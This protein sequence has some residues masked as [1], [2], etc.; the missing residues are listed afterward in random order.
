MH[1][2][3]FA[4]TLPVLAAMATAPAAA[5]AEPL[6]ATPGLWEMTS[7]VQMHGPVLSP[8]MMA[9][10]PPSAR[11]QVEA[12]MKTMQQPHTSR[13]CITEQKLR[14]GF[15]FDQSR[16]GSCQKL[17][18][19]TSSSGFEVKYQC[20]EGDGAS[21]VMHARFGLTGRDHMAGT[22]DMDRAGGEGPQHITGQVEGHW[23]SADCAGAGGS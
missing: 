1:T 7:T 18:Y 8:E 20:S 19:T 3:Y 23:V 13:T 10:I 17:E 14:E 15:N 4:R 11:A 16:E 12:A 9:Q 21:A 22:F 6:N 2:K 5:W